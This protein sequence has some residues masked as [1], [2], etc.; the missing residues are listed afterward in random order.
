MHQLDKIFDKKKIEERQELARLFSKNA[1][2]QL[3]NWQPTTKDGKIAKSIAHG[4]I[5]EV[6]ARMAGNAP[7]SGF[8]STMTNELLIGEI[9]KVAKHDPALAQ[10]L[11]AAVGGV[12][13]KVT[14]GSV[15]TGAAV[16]SYATK[17]NDETGVKSSLEEAYA[18]MDRDILDEINRQEYDDLDFLSKSIIKGTLIGQSSDFLASRFGEY[19]PNY[20]VAVALYKHALHGDGEK[21]YFP[22][23]TGASQLISNYYTFID[24]V[25]EN[26]A[27]MSVGESK[28]QY[29]V[30]KT[31]G[32]A[33]AAF[34]KLKIGVRMTKISEDKVH[35]VGQAKDMYNFEWLPDYDND[36]PAVPPAEFSADYIAKL[37]SIA[38]DTSKQGS[39][40]AANNIAY[41]EQRAGIIKPYK[42]GIQIDTVI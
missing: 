26:S 15:N 5:G 2:E 37:L 32:N 25:K 39:L 41:L 10:W 42:Y 12:V 1:F 17:W 33:R 6:A 28:V 27:D 38:L 34:G 7:G 20:S 19:S 30:I 21:Q 22:L 16:T 11:S 35:V 24:G 13:N 9:K 31:D 4:I 23:G 14:G 40:I 8:K 18:A 36:I 3:H 29:F